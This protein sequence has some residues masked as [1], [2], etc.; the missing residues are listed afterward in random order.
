ML[1]FSTL[2]KSNLIPTM[3]LRVSPPALNICARCLYRRL[4]STQPLHLSTT[5]SPPSSAQRLQIPRSVPPSGAA[6]LTT[7]ALISL[8]GPEA[9]P[10]LQGLISANLQP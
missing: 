6:R 9:V 10:F 1:H 5:P 8:H 3:R 4:F 7:R 2:P